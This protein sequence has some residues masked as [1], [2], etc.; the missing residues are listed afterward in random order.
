V[1]F[2]Q[3]NL[4]WS[5]PTTSYGGTPPGETPTFTKFSSQDVQQ[6]TSFL[7]YLSSIVDLH[8]VYTT[9]SSSNIKLGYENM[10]VGGYANYP[11]D[12]RIYI[13]DD[14]VGKI[15]LPSANWS[16]AVMHELLHALGLK[17]PFE[18]APTLPTALGT[19]E[20]SLMSYT[21]STSE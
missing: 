4:T 17:H 5:T 12:G 2:T 19:T 11:P 3:S 16:I 1:D 15:S 10:T 9:A 8:F 6:V 13:N 18:V 7:S 21:I 20:A 14:A